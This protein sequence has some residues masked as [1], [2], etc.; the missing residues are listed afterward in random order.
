MNKNLLEE[1]SEIREEIKIL[2]KRIE[3]K[4]EQLAKIR[5][6]GT[7]RDSVK[8]GY[9]GTQ[10]FRIEGV[11]YGTIS[12]IQ[13]QLERQEFIL[14]CRSNKL[15]EQETEVERFI[16]DMPTSELRQIATLKYIEGRE[17]EEVAKKMGPGR[18]ATGVRLLLTRYCN[19]IWS[20]YDDAIE[21]E[22]KFV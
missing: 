22:K 17:W 15:I 18:T 1:Y 5:S 14:K 12:L 3:K 11:P 4:R 16:S 6:E 19:K 21:E 20:E 2:E 8:G 13:D 9:G 7:V 10:V